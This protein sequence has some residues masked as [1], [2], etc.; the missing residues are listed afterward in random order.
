[1]PN[2][3]TLHAGEIE[4]RGYEEERSKTVREIGRKW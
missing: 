1:V 2:K 3:N 4:T